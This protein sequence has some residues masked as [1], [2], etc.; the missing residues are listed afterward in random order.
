M[1]YI[2]G[3]VRKRERIDGGE[4]YLGVGMGCPSFLLPTLEKTVESERHVNGLAKKNEWEKGEKKASC[5]NSWSP[6]FFE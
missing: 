3:R 1:K 5:L 4:I 2:I 6:C